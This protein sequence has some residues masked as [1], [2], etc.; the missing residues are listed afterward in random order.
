MCVWRAG[1][2]YFVTNMLPF[3]SFFSRSAKSQKHRPQNKWNSQ[4][5]VSGLTHSSHH[6]WTVCCTRCLVWVLLCTE[7]GCVTLAE[8]LVAAFSHLYPAVDP[9]LKAGSTSFLFQIQRMC[10]HTHRHSMSWCD[11]H[12]VLIMARGY[13]SFPW[14]LCMEPVDA[15]GWQLSNSVRVK[16][17][18]MPGVL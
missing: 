6:G 9:R 3:F 14:L 2:F 15:T 13:S 8:L 4:C 16:G 10:V 7:D 12:T 1:C 18:V 17:F 11:S 5:F